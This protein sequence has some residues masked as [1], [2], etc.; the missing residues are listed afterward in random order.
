MQPGLAISS[1]SMYMSFL[2]Q[3][4]SPTSPSATDKVEWRATNSGSGGFKTEALTTG[5]GLGTAI[6]GTY[7][8]NN[9][10]TLMGNGMFMIITKFGGLGTA[11]GYSKTWAINEAAYDSILG[12]GITEAEIDEVA[13]LSAVSTTTTPTTLLDSEIFRFELTGPKTVIIDEIKIG[14]TLSAVVDGAKVVYGDFTGDGN[15]NMEDLKLFAAVWL[16][17]DCVKTSQ[18]DLD[19]DCRVDLYEF[20]KMSKNWLK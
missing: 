3:G 14:T 13:V 6:V 9:T 15:V 1:V 8:E 19:G 11:K 12:D 16:E 5:G 10:S 4:I 18:M 17:N 2:Y 20:S 7:G